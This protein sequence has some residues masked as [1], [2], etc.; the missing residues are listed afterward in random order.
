MKV[1]SEDLRRK[2]VSAHLNSVYHKLGVSSRGAAV[3]IA[4]EHG[5][6]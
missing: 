5:L 6:A 3:R 4:L 2:I 1:R